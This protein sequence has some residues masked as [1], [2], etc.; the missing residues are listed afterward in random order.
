MACSGCFGF[1]G[2]GYRDVGV[3]I[4]VWVAIIR[5]FLVF[6][7]SG[8]GFDCCV[9]LFVFGVVRVVFASF[10]FCYFACVAFWIVDLCGF[11]VCA[12]LLRPD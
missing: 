10:C 3:L 5:I 2:F 11:L 1:G 12:L 4:H 8:F 7:S 6:G 9:V